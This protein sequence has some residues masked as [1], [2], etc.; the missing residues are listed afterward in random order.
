MPASTLS[1]HNDQ[2]HLQINLCIMLAIESRIYLYMC[3]SPS[4]Y[5]PLIL[6]INNS[7]R[8]FRIA[9]SLTLGIKMDDE[10]EPNT[11][12]ADPNLLYCLLLY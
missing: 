8:E 5:L 10:S 4:L 1:R 7:H 12:W 3:V 11:I 2:D 6:S 9:K